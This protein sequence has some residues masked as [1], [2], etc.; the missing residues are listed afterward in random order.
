MIEANKKILIFWQGNCTINVLHPSKSFAFSICS[1]YPMKNSILG[2]F[3]Q[4]MCSQMHRK[5][6]P[7]MMALWK[8]I[9]ELC[10]S[11]ARSKARKS[12]KTRK[13]FPEIF[14][15]KFSILA[16]GQNRKLRNKKTWNNISEIYQ[17]FNLPPLHFLSQF[18]LSFLQ[19]FFQDLYFTFVT[20]VLYCINIARLSH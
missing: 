17:V 20:T 8:I 2:Y 16:I 10:C 5:L 11:V 12:W 9:T 15:S 1:R 3:C 7:T 18:V 13:F 14:K 19:M 6:Q 4:N